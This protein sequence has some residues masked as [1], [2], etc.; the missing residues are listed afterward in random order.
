MKATAKLGQTVGDA[1]IRGIFELLAKKLE[2]EGIITNVRLG[3]APRALEIAKEFAASNEKHIV[4]I[5]NHSRPNTYYRFVRA[6]A[7][8]KGNVEAI[9]ISALPVRK[10]PGK[11]RLTIIIS[12]DSTYRNI[13][14]R[15]VPVLR[16]IKVDV[17]QFELGDFDGSKGRKA[18]GI[19]YLPKERYLLELANKSK[20][21]FLK[22]IVAVDE[23]ISKNVLGEPIPLW[24]T[25]YR[26]LIEQGARSGNEVC[27]SLYR[28]WE[29]AEKSAKAKITTDNRVRS[30]PEGASPEAKE[31]I[32]IL[33]DIPE[34]IDLDVSLTVLKIA[35][36]IR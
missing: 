29:N 13:W 15:I 4:L 27:L 22:A 21:G 10:E 2:G 16:E 1:R 9:S 18:S 23:A 12:A 24:M 14:H 7:D 11:W 30:V 26:K 35:R 25:E 8:L 19:W 17:E 36:R 32:A 28:Y 33:G 3:M 31:V 20:D 34:G 6:E 5:T